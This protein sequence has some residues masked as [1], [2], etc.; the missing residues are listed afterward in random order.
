MPS[1]ANPRADLHTPHLIKPVNAAF[2]IEIGAGFLIGITFSLPFSLPLGKHDECFEIRQT[3]LR[4]KSR[5]YERATQSCLLRPL[6]Q[7]GTAYLDINGWPQSDA[8]PKTTR[9]YDRSSDQITLD[10]VER[11][12]I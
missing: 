2:L 9:L 12:L 11:I 5:W 6:E 7:C 8:S 10:L 3:Y 4:N 1:Y